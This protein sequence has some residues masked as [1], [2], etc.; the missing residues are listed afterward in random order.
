MPKYKALYTDFP[1][2]DAD[3]ERDLLAKL[4]CELVISPDNKEETL[5]TLAP[6]SDCILTCWAPTTARV[7]AA[8]GKCRHIARTGI[9]LDNIDVEY[10]TEYG[11]VVTNVPDYCILEVAEQTLASIFS[12]ARN[13]HGYHLA[14]KQGEYD[15][16]KGLPVTR[17]AGKTLGIVGL[18]RIGSLVAEKALALGMEVVANNRSQQVPE[19]VEWLPF[20]EL[21]AVSDYVSLHA[22][23][24]EATR[25]LMNHTALAQMKPTAALINTS[26]GGLV[27]H[28]ALAHALD[29]GLLAGAALDVQDPEPPDLSQPPWNHPKVLVTPH[30]AF[31]SPEAVTELRERVGQQVVDFLSGKRP[32]NVV[33]PEVL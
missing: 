1:W 30:T 21:L 14:T 33:N 19:G 27:D 12:L 23:L 18:G 17:V 28:D 10:A 9:G 6:G 8:A 32:E 31:L 15:L 5:I 22:P 13:A 20:E 2:A 3:I 4:D 11:I 29:E 7:I 16:V 25:R 24:T 26:R